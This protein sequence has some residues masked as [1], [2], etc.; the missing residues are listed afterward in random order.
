MEIEIICCHPASSANDDKNV[1][2]TEVQNDN[3]HNEKTVKGEN[4]LVNAK[5]K[6][7]QLEFLW[8]S[9]RTESL[10]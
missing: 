1:L 7:K 3:H 6:S 2:H 5:G 8:K 10:L 4:V 9:G